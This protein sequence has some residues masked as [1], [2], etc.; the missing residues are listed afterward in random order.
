MRYFR[1]VNFKPRKLPKVLSLDEFKGNSGGHKYNSII[2]DPQNHKVIDILPDRY[3][4]DLVR[5]FAQF[6][7]KTH[8][9]Y[10]IC[11]LS[12]HF[13]RVA[14]ICFPNARIVADKFHV[15]RQVHGFKTS[16]FRHE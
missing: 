10:F 9:E 1:Y 8:A 15:I 12:T 2:A 6:K 13:R 3:E 11:D 4:S 14:K 16:L 7:S 5:Y